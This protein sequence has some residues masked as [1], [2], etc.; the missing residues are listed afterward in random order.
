[1]LKY[2]NILFCLTLCQLSFSQKHTISGYVEDSNTGE[3]IIGAYV[4]DS[5]SRNVAQ[6]NNYGFYNLKTTGKEA[7]IKATYI[8]FKSEP[9]YLAN[10]HD[11]VLNI[12]IHPLM[13]LSEVV[14]TSSGYNHTINDQLGMITIP[15]KKLTQMPALGE[16]D[17]LKSIQSQPG[18]KGGVE[19]SS[20]IFVRG[21]GSGENLFML[22]DVPIYNVSHL[23]GFF[24]A[25][26]SDAIKDI[27]LLKGCFPAQYGGRVS[28]VI[29]V[30]S[31]DGNNKSLKG[32]M[33]I[34]IISANVTLEGPVINDKTTFIFSGRRSYFDL[35]SKALKGLELL[36]SDFP[37]YNFYDINARITHTFSL[38][39][40]IFISFY[41]GKDRIKNKI[42]NS[43]DESQSYLLSDNYHE[44]SGWGNLISSLRWNHTVGNSLFAN[45][46]VAYSRYKYFTQDKYHMIYSDSLAKDYNAKYNSDI[47]DFII[48]TDFDYSISNKN[49]LKF[50]IGNTFHIFKPGRNDYAVD[51]QKLNVKTDTSYTNST[52]HASELFIYVEDEIK[53][54]QKLTVN[55]GIRFSSLMSG[56]KICLNLE[57]RISATYILLPQ[58]VI[59]VGYSRMVQYMHLLTR[60]GLSM[61]TDIWVPA[62]KGLNP[63]KSDQVN[64]GVSYNWSN[65]LLLSLEVYRK[66]L[67]NTT[68]YKNGSSLL[69]DLSPWYEKITQGHGNAKGIELSVEKQEGRLTGGINY[70][71]SRSDRK[72]EDLNNGLSF[73]FKYDRLYDF[74][75][76]VNYQISKKW[77]VSSFWMYGTGYP[78]TTPVDKYIPNFFS[79]NIYYYPSINNSR[80]P[81]Y[82]RLDL[83][84][85]YKTHNHV[86]YQTISIDVFNAY[87]RK[88][89]VNVYYIGWA[90]VYSYLLPIIPSVTYT[91]NFK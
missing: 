27:K 7:F 64:A 71:I 46:T 31:R 17:L 15:V 23:Y 83:G 69:T 61:P 72:Y 58:L 34:G 11:T 91:L 55:S 73:P 3:R 48:K 40:K 63:L 22:D 24:S 81:A 75:I 80:L 50:G 82:H 57:P 19:G 60:F 49:K 33:S 43:N 47:S 84:I 85:H 18:I 79:H 56:G 2:I 45:T 14:V 62:L 70:T 26:N 21:G 68:D 76:S 37:G 86:G 89:P 42:D 74:N 67:F 13:E 39:D 30:R 25:F 6:T 59:K 44:D 41:N 16:S 9:V 66:W 87:Y 35:Y 38:K 32:Q 20:G 36:N 52:L 77:D 4:T 1:M 90:F 53:P 29:D 78:V 54:L 65:K 28:S 88:N 51:D 12:K 10:M 5:L 8:G